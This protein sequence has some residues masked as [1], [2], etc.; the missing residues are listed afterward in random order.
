HRKSG[1][2]QANARCSGGG[3]GKGG[4]VQS[5]AASE[6]RIEFAGKRRIRI[7]EQ[8]FHIAACKHCGDV[9]ESGGNEAPRGR[10]FIGLDRHRRR[11][12]AGAQQCAACSLRVAHEVSDVIE[13]NLIAGGKLAAACGRH[14][15]ARH[16]NH[17]D[18]AMPASSTTLP[19]RAI[20]DCRNSA[21]SSGEPAPTGIMPISR[22]RA[23]TSFIATAALSSALSF[24]TIA[25]GVR[26]GAI[27]PCHAAASKP[28]TPASASGG[29]SGKTE[30]G[31]LVVTASARTL[32]LL[33][34][35]EA[36][37]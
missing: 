15:R 21:S 36:G 14:R 5:S 20:S 24:A 27:T 16:R 7:F 30:N 11:C 32:P 35:G 12:E 33:M 1:A 6:R 31:C 22:M 19:Q 18:R 37:P 34:K 10:I 13:K 3:D 9:A 29:T 4:E 26:A 25:G 28:G 8:H 17:S 23:R 2:G